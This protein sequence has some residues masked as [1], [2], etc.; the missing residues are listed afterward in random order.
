[1][2][3][4]FGPKI[5]GLLLAAGLSRRMGAR[6]KLTQKIGDV[7]MVRRAAR[8]LIDCGLDVFVVLGHE[9]DD[10]AAALSG[11]DLTLVDNPDYRE[12]QPTSM[13]AGLKAVGGDCDAV[14]V[15]LGDQPLLDAR[16]L[17]GLLAAYEG[18]DETKIMI[19]FYGGERGN[20]IIL[21]RAIVDEIGERP[22][23]FGCRKFIESNPDKIAVYQAANDHFTQDIDTPEALA[24]LEH[25]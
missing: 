5:A 25:A 24:A 8:N 10:V 15:A 4:E 21:P 3:G 7:E 6:N 18:S 23:N 1:M 9:R 22:V 16:D 12:G 19:P 2:T 20:P 13:R 17:T 14:L 11:L